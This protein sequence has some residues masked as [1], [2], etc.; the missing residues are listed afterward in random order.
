MITEDYSSSSLEIAKC[1]E[2]PFYWGDEK[3][4]RNSFCRFGNGWGGVCRR[5]KNVTS[6]SHWLD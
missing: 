1:G 6:I 4:V 3:N 2:C 5:Q